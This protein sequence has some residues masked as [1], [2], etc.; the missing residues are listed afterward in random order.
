MELRMIHESYHSCE[1]D[2]AASVAASLNRPWAL[3]YCH[4][5][6]FEYSNSA[7]TIGQ[8]I[9][10]GTSD[11]YDNLR[12]YH[13]IEFK[14]QGVFMKDTLLSFLSKKK[15][16]YPVVVS[17]DDLSCPWMPANPLINRSHPVLVKEVFDNGFSCMDPYFLIE[18]VFF[19]L[20]CIP[21]TGAKVHVVNLH[22]IKTDNSFFE[23]Q[24]I[25]SSYNIAKKGDMANALCADMHELISLDSEIAVHNVLVRSDLLD[26]FT[27]L[28]R[29]RKQ[30][31]QFIIATDDLMK[32]KYTWTYTLFNNFASSWEM[33]YKKL[34]KS[35]CMSSWSK[36]K[37]DLITLI[38]K[39][40]EQ[41][42]SLA[43]QI[44]TKEL[45]GTALQMCSS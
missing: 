38:C 37:S 14:E 25:Q 21:E 45:S 40:L 36:D 5:W 35:F 11:F 41:E 27:Y 13:G 2:I 39:T 43:T 24:I 20:D 12:Q 1:E 44:T 10:E 15:S 29:R 31:A 8:R 3:M 42:I 19:P 23:S 30:Y 33:A 18:D 32:A 22:D 28:A 4:A 34:M 7:G 16:K 26:R 17:V 9:H 6:G